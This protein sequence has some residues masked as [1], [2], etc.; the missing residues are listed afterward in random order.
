MYKSQQWLA[1]KHAAQ[2]PRAGS[3][4]VLD[5]LECCLHFGCARQLVRAAVLI[6]CCA[7]FSAVLQRLTFAEHGFD[8]VGIIGLALCQL[9][10]HYYIWQVTYECLVAAKNSFAEIMQFQFT[11]CQV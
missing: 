1:V 3:E 11:E 5:A 8:V 2:A 10:S 4:F 6:T 7:Q 9:V